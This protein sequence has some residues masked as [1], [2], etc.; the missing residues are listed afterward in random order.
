[1]QVLAQSLRAANIPKS[2]LDQHDCE[3]F[4]NLSAEEGISMEADSV[5]TV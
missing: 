3:T 5:V 4:V 2:Y 1:M